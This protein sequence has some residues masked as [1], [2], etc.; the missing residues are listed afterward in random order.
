MGIYKRKQENKNST[1]KAIKKSRKKRRKHALDQENDQEKTIAVKKKKKENTL[2]TKKATKKRKTFFFFLLSSFLLWILI[3]AGVINGECQW[4]REDVAYKD[5]L[6]TNNGHHPLLCE[7]AP[8]PWFKASKKYGQNYLWSTFAPR[9]S[10]VN[11]K[12]EMQTL[13]AKIYLWQVL[14]DLLDMVL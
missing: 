1:K 7:M 6:A 10:T 4:L 14:F 13:D 8:M 5:A 2:S 3:S 11:I 9:S 12:I